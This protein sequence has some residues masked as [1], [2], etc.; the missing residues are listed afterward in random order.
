[1]T[2]LAMTPAETPERTVF[3]HLPGGDP[4]EMVCLHGAGGFEARVMTFGAAL[5]ALLVP[6]GTGRLADVVLGHDDL[7]GYLAERNFFG[8][9]IGRFANRIAGGTFALDGET[10]RLPVSNSANTLHGGPEGFDRKPWTIVESGGGGEPFVTLSRTSRDGEEGFPGTLQAEVTYAVTGPGELTISYKATT[11]RPTVV[12]LTN[13]S[14]FNLAGAGD[15]LDHRIM[16]A[17]DRFLPVDAGLIPRGAPRDVAGAPFDFRAPAR[18]GA[19]IR[20]D[21]EQIRLGQGYDHCFCLRDGGDDVRPAV[22]LEGGGRVLEILTD[23]PA[24]QF[25]SGNFLDGSGRGKAGLLHR[26]SDGLCLEPQRFPDAPNRPD[27]PS[28]RLDPGQTY[29]HRSIY[30]FSGA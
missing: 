5:Q 8:A 22:R 6:D 19:R 9:T 16:I 12:N 29:R 28:A 18:I 4:I 2:A 7:D 14:F 27:F 13:H 3:G 10:H 24:V 17:A 20:D 21:H 23:Q 15:V 1:M 11:D 30:R 25:Y 26:Q